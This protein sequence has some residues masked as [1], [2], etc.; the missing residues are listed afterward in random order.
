MS[1]YQSFIHMP[2]S[3]R[4]VFIRPCWPSFVLIIDLFIF[5]H[6]NLAPW[7]EVIADNLMGIAHI[8]CS[9]EPACNEQDSIDTIV[10]TRALCSECVSALINRTARAINLIT[11]LYWIRFFSCFAWPFMC[12]CVWCCCC[13][14]WCRCGLTVDCRVWTCDERSPH[15][16]IQLSE[17]LR[18][19]GIPHTLG[20]HLSEPHSIS[21]N[22]S[23]IIR[24][25]IK[26]THNFIIFGESI[27]WRYK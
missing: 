18:H 4:D 10:Y 9:I 20:S 25:V 23:L 6:F 21:V 3:C 14:C 13:C 24:L 16:K 17:N 22:Y 27:S 26:H 12:L 11:A 7:K 5:P 2:K 15:R 19:F 1:C 8:F